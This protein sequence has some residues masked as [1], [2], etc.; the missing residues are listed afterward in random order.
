LIA[1][2]AFPHDADD[3]CRRLGGEIAVRMQS[4]PGWA[5]DVA[6]PMRFASRPTMG[7]G[8]SA[9]L[10]FARDTVVIPVH[11]GNP[12]SFLVEEGLGA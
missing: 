1:A 5:T 9:P 6:R 12:A 7:V 3:A 4:G 10:A 11:G 2:F 8:S